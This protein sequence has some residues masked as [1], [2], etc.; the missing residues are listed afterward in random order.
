MEYKITGNDMQMVMVELS[1]QEK[2]FATAGA[3][4]YMSGNMNMTTSSRGTGMMGG[5]KRKLIGESFLFTEFAP[6]GGNG[7]VTFAGPAPGTIKTLQVAPGKEYTLQKGSFLCATEGVNLDMTKQKTIGSSMFGGAGWWLQKVSGTGTVF[8]HTF[9]N[10]MEMD[11]APGQS[12]KVDTEMVVG[13][14]PSVSYE[15][16]RAGNVK[17][18]LFGGE[19][20]FLNHLKGPGKVMIQSQTARGLASVLTPYMPKQ[21]ESSSSSRGSGIQINTGGFRR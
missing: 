20:L 9:G 10:M 18:A 2:I 6:Q 14:E 17:T 4:I 1:Q 19:G 3:M 11:L 21:R 12:I 16:T 7:V 8:I 5:I 13:W 15:V